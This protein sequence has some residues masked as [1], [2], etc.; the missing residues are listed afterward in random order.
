MALFSRKSIR[1]RNKK[2]SRKSYRQALWFRPRLEHLEDRTLLSSSPL[3]VFNSATSNLAQNQIPSIVNQALGLPLPMTNDPQTNKPQ[4]L[5]SDLVGV[6]SDIQTPFQTPLKLSQLQGNPNTPI[7]GAFGFTLDDPANVDASGNWTPNQDGNYFEVTYQNTFPSLPAVIVAG[8]T[9]FSYLDGNG[10]LFGAISG[11]ASV[12]FTVTMGVD[13]VAGNPTFFVLD[14]SN[15]PSPPPGSP[16]APPGTSLTA[17]LTAQ[18]TNS[19]SGTLNI[20]GLG[21]VSAS[22]TPNLNLTADGNFNA[23]PSDSNGKIR[24]TDFQNDLNSVVSASFD[25]NSSAS[26]TVNFKASFLGASLSWTGTASYKPNGGGGGGGLWTHAPSLNFTKTPDPASFL[27]GIGNDLFKDAQGIPILGPLSSALN[28]PLPLIN[29]SIGQL[30]GLD[31]DLPQ[32][33]SLP[34]GG[35]TNGTIQNF[36]G[37]T[38]TVN[39]TPQSIE[40]LLNPQPGQTIPPLISWTTGKKSVSLVNSSVDVPIFALGIPD[41]AD[42]ELDAHFGVDASL[43]YDLGFGIDNHGLYFQAGDSSD[44]TLGLSF[45]VNAGLTGSVKIFGFPLASAGGNVGF[46]IEPYVTLTAPP[47]GNGWDKQGNSSYYDSHKVYLSDLQD[48]F[49]PNPLVDLADDVSAGLKGDL[50]GTL[51]V[52]VNLLLASFS[53]SWGLDFPVFNIQ[54]GPKWPPPP[55]PPGPLGSQPPG[56][57]TK[58]QGAVPPVSNSGVLTFKDDPNKT[59]SPN[60]GDTISLSSKSPG[61]VTIAWAGAGSQTFG[62][63]AGQPAI[64]QFDFIADNGSGNNH[65]LVGQ[66][67]NIPIKADDSASSGGDLLES[68][69][70]NDTL[71]GGSGADTLIAGKGNDSLV[72]GSGDDV[73]VGGQGKDFLGADTVLGGP[74]SGSG[75]DTISGGSGD[76]TINPG[77]GS[78]S[79]YTGSG[80]DS[81]VAGSGNDTISAGNGQDTINAGNGNDS[82]SGGNGLETISAGSGQDT[83]LGGSGNSTITVNAGSASDSISAGSGNDIISIVGGSGSDTIDGG[84]GSDIIH[85][86]GGSDTIYGGAGG[87]NQIY[88]GTAGYNLIYGGG[89]GDII[90]GGLGGHDTMHGGNAVISA[91][92]TV[93]K[94]SNQIT[95]QIT[96]TGS[97]LSEL[98]VGQVVTGTGIA[99][100]T[101]ITAITAIDSTHDT[102]TISSNAASSSNSGELLYF[103]ST[104]NQILGGAG[105]FNVIYGSGDGDT[106]AAGIGGNSTI[107]GGTGAETLYG[108]D[109][110]NVGTGPG[111]N[112]YIGDGQAPGNNLLIAGS[113]N[114]VIYGD[115]EQGNNTLQAG[116]GNDILWAGG[117][118]GNGDVLEAGSG[119][120]ALHGGPG[121][122]TL[123]MPYF[124]PGQQQPDVLD[125]GLGA[126]TLVITAAQGVAKPAPFI[127]LTGNADAPAPGTSETITVSNS[128]A[129]ANGTVIQIDGEQMLVTA[130]NVVTVAQQSGNVTSGSNV[131]RGLAN[132]SQLAVGDSIN[133]ASGDI[134][135]GTTIVSIDTTDNQITL[136][137]NAAGSANDALTFSVQK[138][139]VTRGYNSTTPAEHSAEAL[140]E[141][142]V[143]PPATPSNYKINLAPVAGSTNQYQATLSDLNSGTLV[144]EDTFTLPPK[145]ANLELDG[146]AGDNWIQVDPAVS[147][148]VILYGG[149]GHNTLMAGSGNDTLVAGP[150]SSILY[151]GSGDDV[152]YG[153][154]IPGQDVPTLGASGKSG[155]ATPGPTTFGQGSGSSGLFTQA[156]GTV[157]GT[158][159]ANLN[160]NLSQLYTGEYVYGTGIVAGTT[161]TAIASN[162]ILISTPAQVPGGTTENLSFGV[163]EGQDTLIAGAGNAELFAGDG[164]DV[165]IGGSVVTNPSTGLAQLSPTGQFI[166][167]SGAGRDLLEGGSGSDLLI[168]GPGSPG[169]VLTA[170][171]GNDTLVA[172]NNGDN[173]L[174]GGVGKDLLLGGSGNDVLISGSTASGGN[175]L[176]G[177]LGLDTLVGAAGSDVLYAYPDPATWAIT[178]QSVL[179]NDNVLLTPPGLPGPTD[180]IGTLLELQQ[181]QPG[182][183][184]DD[185]SNPNDSNSIQKLSSDLD[186]EFTQL[187][188]TNPPLSGD[189]IANQLQPQ[190][191]SAL[192]DAQLKT[193]VSALDDAPGVEE[194]LQGILTHIQDTQPQG[195]GLSIAQQN[196]L[197]YMLQDQ[198]NQLFAQAQHLQNQI[199]VLPPPSERTPNQQAQAY[200]LGSADKQILN[201]LE[202]VNS[203]IT[204]TLIDSLLG[205]SGKDQLYGNSNYPTYMTGGTGSDTFYNYHTGDTVQGGSAGDNTLVVEGDGTINLTQDLQNPNGIDV[206]IGAKQNGTL[207]NGS[208]IIQ[209]LTDTSQL[210]VGETVTDADGYIPQGTVVTSIV[211]AT[212]I[213]I[214]NGAVIPSNV[215]SPVTDLLTF[216]ATPEVVGNVGNISNVQNLEVQT[217]QGNDTVN[218]D[219]ATLPAGLTGFVVQAGSGNDLIDAT[220]LQNAA[221]L[222][223]GTGNDIIQIGTQLPSNSVYKGGPGQS[224]LDIVGT[225]DLTATVSSGFL[226]VD[227]TPA[228][229]S[230]FDKIVMIGGTGTNNFTSDGT[231]VDN[232]NGTV[233]TVV[234][235]GGSGSNTFNADN[236]TVDMVGGSGENTFNLNMPYVTIGFLDKSSS[237]LLATNLSGT[238]YVTGGNG[239]GFNHLQINGDNYGD[240]I[241]LTQEQP[242][243]ISDTAIAA[244]YNSPIQ[245]IGKSNGGGSINADVVNM[246]PHGSVFIQGG[247]GNDGLDASGILMGVTLNGGGGTDTLIGGG[248][249]NTLD[250]EGTQSTYIGGA[251]VPLYLDGGAYSNTDSLDKGGT[252][253]VGGGTQNT[254]FFPGG[255]PS[256][257]GPNQYYIQ[258]YETL[259]FNP[260]TRLP[261]FETV[262]AHANN[263]ISGSGSIV[264]GSSS[265]V[266]LKSTF[267]EPAEDFPNGSPQPQ[268]TINWGDGTYS[269]GYPGL[270]SGPSTSAPSASPLLLS[271][272][273]TFSGLHLYATKGTY[274]ITVTF[275]DPDGNYGTASTTATD[276]PLTFTG[277]LELDDEV[278]NYYNGSNPP[279]PL[280]TNVQSY[281]VSNNYLKPAI[282]SLHT[283]HTLWQIDAGGKTQLPGSFQTML[284]DPYGGLFALDTSGN[285]YVK[286][287]FGSWTQDD[288][289]V[290]ELVE[291]ANGTIYKWMNNGTLYATAPGAP[292]DQVTNTDVPHWTG[293]VPPNGNIVASV[294]AVSLSADNSTLYVRDFL[295]QYWQ[296]NELSALIGGINSAWTYVGGLHLQL[297][298]P[299]QPPAGQSVPVT[300]N[301]LDYFNNPVDAAPITVHF[302]STDVLAGTPADV[303]FH[304]PSYTVNYAFETAG[305][306]TLTASLANAP[307]PSQAGSASANVTVGPGQPV[308]LRAHFEEASPANVQSSS[309]SPPP[310]PANG[311]NTPN[312]ELAPPN[313]AISGTPLA[314]TVTAYDA[315][316]NIATGYNGTIQFSSG[317][318]RPT[319]ATGYNGAV[320]LSS[321]GGNTGLPSSYAFTAADAGVHT[322]YLTLDTAGAQSITVSD[323]SNPQMSSASPA[324]VVVNPATQLLVTLQPP[325]S[326]TAGQTFGLTVEAVDA[327]GN[328]NPT[329]GGPVTLSLGDNP[330]GGTLGGTLTVNAINGVAT[331]SGLTLDKASIGY[332]LQAASS[333][334]TGTTT[335]AF[336]VSAAEATQLA[337][338]TP[339]PNP[340]A[341]GHGFGLTVSAEDAF[342]N[343]DPTFNG[344]VTLALQNNPGSATLGGTLTVNAVNGAAAFT[345]LTLNQPGIGYTLQ[346]TT[347][348]L[349]GTTT[350]AINVAGAATQLAVTTEPPSSVG[351]DQPFTLAVSTT[352]ALGTIDPTFN[353]AVT[354][355]L[356]NNPGGAALGG[357]LTVNAVNG[358]ATFTGLTL[359]QPGIGYTL[360]VSAGGLTGVTTTAVTAFA[361]L[362]PPTPPPSPPPPPAAPDVPPLLALFN[363]LLG[364]IETVNANGTTITDNLFGFPLVET[365]DY[366]GKLVSVTLLGFNITFLFG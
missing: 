76:C 179:R 307:T 229:I 52:S 198:S 105:G 197:Y 304:G 70:G 354:L 26:L 253:F 281:L 28:Q 355:S 31:N 258:Y 319:I 300:I 41:I 144:G 236:G 39:V 345:G 308:Y 233:T 287:P 40:D 317:G 313:T 27:S 318:D 111:Q 75:N 133:D 61:S 2:A 18:S 89:P 72:A 343:L 364:A 290:K 130:A 221:T 326:V 200:Y 322:F 302:S 352:D 238:Y 6:V 21:S 201:E 188:V 85:G 363:E 9:G 226:Y 123:V 113:G 166:L 207:T 321:S 146:G 195:Q 47:N 86:G 256:Q 225:T 259:I 19:L 135:Q 80:N 149:A 1:S 329:F 84:S 279:T 107:M 204:G 288:A 320:P 168:A 227:T 223:G 178:A 140:V 350:A 344:A 145:T 12:K 327:L 3:D 289:G 222:L 176:V 15:P 254:L 131:I 214:S 82:I 312:I 122:D 276:A 291:D 234:M 299:A 184:V 109:G 114:D 43:N 215:S 42:V 193:L 186:A 314:L 20:G 44:P 35:L 71:I 270:L 286:Y 173:V 124:P 268:A 139:T 125:G 151:G 7:T 127:Y 165:L 294:T 13:N 150:G 274:A 194:E 98:A 241:Q 25:S 272:P 22:A 334:L 339:P 280:D 161:I 228:N 309:T 55:P 213:T 58:W 353:G 220:Q 29:Q 50:T 346:A 247:T 23:T 37:G 199:E 129:I 45:G 351:I 323:T 275:T 283:D 305:A 11:N 59:G 65:L 78:D 67:F 358:V 243:P 295:G 53:D 249:N 163:A 338:T 210:A 92:G 366:S 101:T 244:P 335:G 180:A 257:V 10:G 181:T 185:P 51:T 265:V 32:L 230:N 242:I 359:N 333:G 301:A 205:G 136:S 175:T 282:F 347:N 137:Q 164:G 142:V 69:T 112:I 56:D 277:G 143:Q 30:T 148:N 362:P 33:P 97:K 170:G 74:N 87:N 138:L 206:N 261:E 49:G 100:G 108:G 239:P 141:L 147:Q 126:N 202:V 81:V 235:E 255:I 120:D 24:S 211:S 231:N 190:N 306:Q 311:S 177:G 118:S 361:P 183:L 77:I 83:I 155:F 171:S 182:G 209:L 245:V 169:E 348:P 96:L 284:M 298:V 212:E 340:V 332:A 99:N 330:G 104:N 310:P 95:N 160:I 365:Y 264:P 79:I 189:Q 271:L 216:A 250:Y 88:G 8:S 132:V 57:S 248:G 4:L 154:N 260:I 266:N 106:L 54:S 103:G 62:T 293:L 208:K 217:L 263:E 196:L 48:A 262:P 162:G 251:G 93:V 297:S 337:V 36:F 16:S 219:F 192:T 303:F 90:H 336:T 269:P 158:T 341:A 237:P 66:G 159:I 316:G 325:T 349:N 174:Q 128:A 73:I 357:T 14:S 324:V 278:L 342:G 331:F 121:N 218:V 60:K 356:G 285:L 38:L 115:S 267:S 5:A 94:G 117:V 172:E 232:A 119:V 63:A 110:L 167:T 34:S 156:V 68:G 191:L 292:P 246:G 328:L 187:G 224:E 17:T 116:T 46:Q 240:K 273:V 203:E 252:G 64:T 91:T 152:L 134:P 157:F 296:Y 153:G 102:I 315:F 360:H